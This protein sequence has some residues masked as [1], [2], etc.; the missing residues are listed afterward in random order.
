MLESLSLGRNQIKRI[1]NL[2]NL[3][4]LKRLDLRN[5]QITEPSIIGGAYTMI[6]LVEL[7]LSD[8]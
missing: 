6:D 1:E 2:K 8:N 4:K 7:D 5:N 3:K